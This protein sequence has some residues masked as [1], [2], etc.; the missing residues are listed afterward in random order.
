VRA[1]SSRV[2]TSVRPTRD[3]PL[4]GAALR[5]RRATARP[6]RPTQRTR[7]GRFSLF[8]APSLVSRSWGGIFDIGDLAIGGR[9]DPPA[10]RA[11]ATLRDGSWLCVIDRERARRY[12][13]RA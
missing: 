5:R 12:S 8:Y 6:L 7:R 13:T 3:T 9:P 10:L 4:E 2:D 11:A 1:G